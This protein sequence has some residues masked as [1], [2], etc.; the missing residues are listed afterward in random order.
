MY[1][2]DR[3]RIWCR[4]FLSRNKSVDLSGEIVMDGDA[5][6]LRLSGEKGKR[7][8]GIYFQWNTIRKKNAQSSELK[9]LP[10]YLEEKTSF[11]RKA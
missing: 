3:R 5:K 10:N 1:D 11:D 7:F 4:H 9:E 2:S 8:Y 6:E